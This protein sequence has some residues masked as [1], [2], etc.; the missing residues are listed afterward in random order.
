MVDS[1][2][3]SVSARVVSLEEACCLCLPFTTTGRRQWFAVPDSLFHTD[4][5]AL[6]SPASLASIGGVR[7]KVRVSPY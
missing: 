2:N 6:Q 3:G 1:T 7:L 5:I 4:I